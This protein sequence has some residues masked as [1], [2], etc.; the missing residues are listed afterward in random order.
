MR[1]VALVDMIVEFVEN[2]EKCGAAI[3]SLLGALAAVVPAVSCCVAFVSLPACSCGVLFVTRPV[4]CLFGAL[5][6][7]LTA[8]A[9]GSLVAL[10]LAL[11][12]CWLVLFFT[13]LA[14][15]VV[16]PLV[17]ASFVALLVVPPLLSASYE[18]RFACG[19]CSRAGCLIA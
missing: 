14:S 18:E 13:A 1:V 15:G 12:F 6:S 4:V 5:A 8:P 7:V 9:A 3:G 16:P 10:S 2:E 11:A 17:L 19:K